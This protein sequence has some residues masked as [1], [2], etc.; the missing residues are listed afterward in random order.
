VKG[1]LLLV[2]EEG[3]LLVFGGADSRTTVTER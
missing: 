1:G 3:G 2:A